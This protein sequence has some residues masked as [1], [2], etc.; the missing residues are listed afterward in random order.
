MIYLAKTVFRFAIEIS[1]ERAPNVENKKS[2]HLSIVQRA[3]AR[4]ITYMMSNNR[5]CDI[6][7]YTISRFH[8]KCNSMYTIQITQKLMILH[9]KQQK[10]DIS[11]Q[12]QVLHVHIYTVST[13]ANKPSV[14]IVD[15]MLP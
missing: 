2:Q 1:I 8:A 14:K 11:P 7:K 10:M 5:L 3:N 6:G 12:I 15:N 4:S 13:V 9:K